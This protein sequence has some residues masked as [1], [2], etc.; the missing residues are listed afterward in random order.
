MNPYLCNKDSVLILPGIA[1]G[2]RM[3]EC[4]ILEQERSGSNH[5]STSYKLNDLGHLS[6]PCT[7][8]CNMGI[9]SVHIL[10][11]NIL[12]GFREELVK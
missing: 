12:R 9:T 1:I 7:P 10:C 5:S 11:V 2:D 3:A 8:M 4:L 6:E